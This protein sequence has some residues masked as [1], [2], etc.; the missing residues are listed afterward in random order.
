[1]SHK[2]AVPPSNHV[3]IL[4]QNRRAAGDPAFFLYSE[5]F[6]MRTTRWNPLLALVALLVLSACGGGGGGGGGNNLDRS[7]ADFS[8]DPA[9][10]ADA[11]AGATYTATA[12]VT[13]FDGT[14][15]ARISAS[16]G[17]AA[18]ALLSEGESV[19]EVTVSKGSTLTLQVIVDANAAADTTAS[20]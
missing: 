4:L 20:A 16:E 6:M 1:V 11:R 17:G 10:I 9:Q 19:E 14:L 15:P 7:P 12:A 13:G 8:F 5:V 18:F 2:A 3:F